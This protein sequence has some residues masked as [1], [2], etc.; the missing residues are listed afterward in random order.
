MFGFGRKKKEEREA[1]AS[2][3]KG[4]PVKGK[5]IS[6]DVTI[7]GNGNI[8]DGRLVIVTQPYSIAAEQY[9]VLSTR[10]SLITRS[11][12]SYVLVVTSAVKGEGK[13]FTTLNMAI[14]MAQDFEEDILLIEG[15][16]KHPDIHEYLKQNPGFG[17]VDVLEGKVDFESATVD[18]FN[19]RLKILL[20][21]T[22]AGN[23]LRLIASERMEELLAMAR[24]HFKVILIDTP[25]V[26][27]LADI[28]LYA[29]FADGI[30]V[31]IK[32][33]KT[34]RSLVKKAVESLPADKIIGTVLNEVDENS[35][36]YYYGKYGY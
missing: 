30:L 2:E 7:R 22:T 23:P 6:T 19:G 8:V 18:L 28:N 4:L 34:P 10:L 32:A 20:A 1:M 36:P 29:T 35:A 14:S 15:D 25:P 24:K 13:T 21:G 16:L 27:P 17:L 9:R 33:G 31:V 11:K 26:I 12:P 3:A 5:D